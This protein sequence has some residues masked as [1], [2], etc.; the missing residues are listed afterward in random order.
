[1]TTQILKTDDGQL[2][3]WF[4]GPAWDDHVKVATVG[5]CKFASV[6]AGVRLLAEAA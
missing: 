2:T 5:K 6:E 3:V 1:M 4:D